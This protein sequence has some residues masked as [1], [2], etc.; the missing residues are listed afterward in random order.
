MILIT[1]MLIAKFVVID[2]YDNGGDYEFAPLGAGRD[3]K[4]YINM[5][6]DNE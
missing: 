4:T 2:F 5:E 1:F 6:N 3:P